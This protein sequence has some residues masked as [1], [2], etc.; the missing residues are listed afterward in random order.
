MLYSEIKIRTIMKKIILL[1][2]FFLG[3]CILINA[4]NIER[5][6]LK[7]TPSG[8]DVFEGTGYEV[9]IPFAWGF[10]KCYG[11]VH[12]G[13]AKKTNEATSSVYIYKGKRYTAMQVIGQQYFPNPEVGLTNLTADV[14]DGAY[15]LGNVKLGNVTGFT[16]GCFG[17][18]YR[19]L[20]MIEIDE[21]KYKDKLSSLSLK[22]VRITYCHTNDTPIETKIDK[23]LLGK[24]FN[25][26]IKEADD[27]FNRRDY[28]K[29]KELYKKANRGNF[30]EFNQTHT[31]TQLEKIKE[32]E[33][34][35]KEQEIAKEEA[36]KNE[37]SS[38]ENKSDNNSEIANNNS[39]SDNNDNNSSN[40]SSNSNT[41]SNKKTSSNSSNSSVPAP[42][43]D[44][45]EV[46]AVIVVA[47]IALATVYATYK[48]GKV[49]YTDMG[50][51]DA[52]TQNGNSDRLTKRIGFTATSAPMTRYQ[53]STLDL[54]GGIDYWPLHGENF[55]I[56]GRATLSA[57]IGV[58][59]QNA[60]LSADAGLMTYYGSEKLRGVFEYHRGFRRYSVF[61]WIFDDLNDSENEFYHRFMA[62]VSFNK[63]TS[64]YGYTQAHIDLLGIYENF[65]NPMEFG[66]RNNFRP[67]SE[68]ANYGIRLNLRFEDRVSFYAETVLRR[69]DKFYVKIGAIR[70]FD[71]FGSSGSSKKSSRFIVAPGK[72]VIYPLVTSFH[73]ANEK[74]S[75]DST[76]TTSSHIPFNFGCRF[77]KDF[78]INENWSAQGGVGLSVLHST[79][80]NNYRYQHSSLNFSAGIRYSK[81]LFNKADKYWVLGGI[82]NRI[83]VQKNITKGS[84]RIPVE[85]FETNR[86]IPQ[87]MF[88]AGLDYTVG[89]LGMRSGIQYERS[90]GSLYQ[91]DYKSLTSNTISF[92]WGFMF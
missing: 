37:T 46:A 29:A 53:T 7:Y 60:Q 36:R 21:K 1:I 47:A 40:S 45:S 90:I 12:V 19:V 14:Y 41:S 30:H 42:S 67:L 77:E 32:I 70:T 44:Y 61:Q 71:K 80:Y 17:E 27:A 43:T 66:G 88:G 74:S 58:F 5:K 54:E 89:K 26:L 31:K 79:R 83:N 38:S 6:T 86:F 75:L 10:F 84:E 24:E 20:K 39:S 35:K 48:I 50:D 52:N 22:N 23:L 69:R 16:V 57:G 65:N 55:G 73:W 59:Y 4:Q 49:I 81:Y 2:T 33:K 51:L 56:G 62:G 8:D 78:N 64:F 25:S 72:N 85:S 18:T 68:N 92:N 15:R 63:Q 76:I 3:A 28:E 11:E 34:E 91:D 87:W 9:N 13:F 82:N